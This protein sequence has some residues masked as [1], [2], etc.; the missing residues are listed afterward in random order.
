MTGATDSGRANRA[1]EHL[2]AGSCADLLENLLHGEE[3][4]RALAHLRICAD[5]ERRF[6]S[7]YSDRE[8]ARTLGRIGRTA[9]GQIVLERRGT[10]AAGSPGP[11]ERW[12]GLLAALVEPVRG[13]QTRFAGLLA[14]TAIVAVGAVLLL[15]SA[16]SDL[17][18][19]HRLP[20]KLDAFH[21]R[22]ADDQPRDPDL[23]AGLEA[24]AKG[25][26]E[27]SARRLRRADVSGVE[28]ITRDLYLAS[29]LAERGRHRE[30]RDRLQGL[31]LEQIPDP[32]GSEASWTL[33]VCLRALGEKAS[34]DSLL[35]LLAHY[36]GEVGRRARALE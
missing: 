5:C 15:R 20:G 25:E 11:G 35:Q 29:A 9:D 36:P 14:A 4:S 34:A 6:R 32:W 13:R 27:R 30:A 31:P 19:L 12:R 3:R 7:A 33:Y 2:T 18:E 24:Y 8:H 16:P 23:L 22:S 28:E 1:G 26:M 17:P 21:F 10:E